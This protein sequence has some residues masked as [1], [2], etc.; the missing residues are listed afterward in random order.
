MTQRNISEKFCIFQLC[1][2]VKELLYILSAQGE[3]SHALSL[4]RT[5]FRRVVPAASAA[6]ILNCTPPTLKDQFC[7][8]DGVAF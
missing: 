5:V 6:I 2:N 4:L 1:H 7:Y 3:L 8:G